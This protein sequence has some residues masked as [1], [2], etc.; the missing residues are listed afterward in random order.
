MV[1]PSLQS[2][3]ME[4]V[5]VQLAEYFLSKR[6]E[7]HMVLYGRRPEIFYPIPPSLIIHKPKFTFNNRWRFYYTLLT[8]LF[9]R[10][11]IKSIH[12][13]SILS[14]GELWNSFVLLATLGLK[15]PVYVSDRCQPDKRLGKIHGALRK[16]L[17]PKSAGVICQTETARQ[18]YQSMFPRANFHVI[19]NPIRHIEIGRK[20]I[21][22]NIIL[23]VGRLIHTKHFDELIQIFA[24]INVSD[25][26]L[27]IVG[28]DA[29]K[30]QNKE[31]LA[32]L[33]N[34]LGMQ[35]RITLAGK[36]TDVDEFYTRAKIFAFTSS[37]EGFPNVIGEA[38]SAG[39][40]VIA[41][42]CIAGPAEM[43]EHGQTGFLVPLHNKE[44]FKNYLLD[45][46]CDESKRKNM[47]EKSRE[48]IKAFSAENIGKKFEILLTGENFTN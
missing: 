7:V 42:D 31:K 37:S 14:F 2:G 18:I 29:L 21:R 30:Q 36:R 28:D 43:I 23:S 6:H 16:W 35:D 22:E 44:L 38:M 10:R 15:Y 3:G 48:K 39:L 5:M 45:L 11:T 26:K 24:E 47:G 27:V 8:L 9:V 34:N 33:I 32:A 1:I 4:R 20:I 41:Y 25:W 12:P 40:P 19:G 13:D 46:I 17:Y